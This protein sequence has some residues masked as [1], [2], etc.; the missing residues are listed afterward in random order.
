MYLRCAKL[1]VI[2]ES[3]NHDV[4]VCKWFWAVQLFQP[5][6]FCQKR[7]LFLAVSLFL[8]CCL[9]SISSLCLEGVG[10]FAKLKMARWWQFRCTP[11]LF[12]AS[13]IFSVLLF[14]RKRYRRCIIW[15][16]HNI[17]DICISYNERFQNRVLLSL[18]EYYESKKESKESRSGLHLAFGYLV[19]P[20][21]ALLKE[22]QITASQPLCICLHFSF[23]ANRI[24]LTITFI[25]HC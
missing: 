19:Q 9:L 5:Q 11:A 14:S 25:E 10:L 7:S 22:K 17:S 13:I 15:V 21:R 16:G 3:Q 18:I 12:Y 8:W 4:V 1:K 23:L 20:V 6:V 24:I 2:M